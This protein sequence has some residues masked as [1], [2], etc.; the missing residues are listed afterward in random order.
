MN[1]LTII[2]MTIL[3]VCNNWTMYAS[4][5]FHPHGINDE[6]FTCG[7]SVRTLS[8][9][10]IGYVSEKADTLHHTLLVTWSRY[11]VFPPF[12]TGYLGRDWTSAGFYELPHSNDQSFDND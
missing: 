10:I 4:A 1:Y 5:P 12:S 2:V 7:P 9:L 11:C 8:Q 3:L 6:C